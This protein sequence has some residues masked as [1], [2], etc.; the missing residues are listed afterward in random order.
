MVYPRSIALMSLASGRKE[1]TRVCWKTHRFN[2]CFYF[3]SDSATIFS[4]QSVIHDVIY[5]GPSASENL[6]DSVA[7]PWTLDIVTSLT[8][9]CLPGLTLI[10]ASSR[11]PSDGGWRG[12]PPAARHTPHQ[13]GTTVACLLPTLHVHH[14]S[15]AH[16]TVQNTQKFKKYSSKEWL[17]AWMKVS[18]FINFLSGHM[19]RLW[20]GGSLRSPHSSISLQQ[21]L[22][23]STHLTRHLLQRITFGRNCNPCPGWKAKV[24]GSFRFHPETSMTGWCGGVKTQFLFCSKA[25]WKVTLRLGLDLRSHPHL[26]LFPFLPSFPDSFSCL[27]GEPDSWFRVCFWNHLFLRNMSGEHLS[28]TS[29]GW[30]VIAW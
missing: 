27:M 6:H 14:L 13:R 20:R 3:A 26:A 17:I 8:P 4:S 18:N 9:F 23:D 24:P 19:S 15:P 25:P 28:S 30:H 21:L 11:G 7:Q 5:L 1:P 22:L 2:T 10:I 12:V 29:C 16:C